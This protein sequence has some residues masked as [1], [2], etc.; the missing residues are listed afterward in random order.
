MAL[1]EKQ[2]QVYQFILTH[3]QAHER[4]PTQREIKEHFNLKS[5][6]SVQRYL[7]YLEQ[8]GLLEKEWNARR[9]IRPVEV[10]NKTNSDSHSLSI[11]LLGTIAAG[12]PLLA[13]EDADEFV[14]IPSSLVKRSGATYFALRVKGDSM[15]EAGILNGDLAIL[16][17]SSKALQGDIVAAMIDQEATLKQFFLSDKGIELRAHNSAYPSLWAKQDRDFAILGVLKAIWRQY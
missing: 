15:I 8:E 1:T 2:E 13:F 3:Y 11:P 5:F 10:D 9:G 17:Q 14:Q 4:A 7:S 16:A 12:S 6:G